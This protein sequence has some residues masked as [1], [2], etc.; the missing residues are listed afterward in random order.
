[1]RYRKGDLVRVVG[2]VFAVSPV[3]PPALSRGTLATLIQLDKGDICIVDSSYETG[4]A[5]SQWSRSRG[6]TMCVV[7]A[8]R[9][10]VQCVLSEVQLEPVGKNDDTQTD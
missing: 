1:M 10:G 8:L 2:D 5:S 9:A 6:Q 3:N 4:G 7:L